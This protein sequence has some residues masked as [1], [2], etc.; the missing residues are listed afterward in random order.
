MAHNKKLGR[1]DPTPFLEARSPSC[2]A[3]AFLL[4]SWL[5][6]QGNNVLPSLS[7]SC[8]AL[9]WSEEDGSARDG[10][11]AGIP[12]EQWQLVFGKLKVERKF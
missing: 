10:G 5:P 12:V 1:A 3:S 7:A 8:I 9:R 11:D 4:C 2:A 6:A